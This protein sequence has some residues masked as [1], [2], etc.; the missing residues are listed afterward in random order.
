[1]NHQ[2]TNYSYISLAASAHG[3]MNRIPARTCVGNETQEPD[4]VGCT[5]LPAAAQANHMERQDSPRARGGDQYEELVSGEPDAAIPQSEAEADALLA[6]TGMGE[7]RSFGRT[8][9]IGDRYL[10]LVTEGTGEKGRIAR[11]TDRL[12]TLGA[13]LVTR[14][15]N[16][17]LAEGLTPVALTTGMTVESP[18]ETMARR[19]GSGLADAAERAGIL[20]LRGTM[21]IRPDMGSNLAVVGT[22]AG[23]AEP[24]AVFPGEAATGDRLVGFPSGGI[25]S[26][27]IEL[28]LETLTSAYELAEPLP[29]DRSR[30]IGDVLVEPSR[31]YTYLTDALRE[32]T[33]HAA[34]VIGDNGWRD[35]DGMGE[36]RYTISDTF[37]PQPLFET[38]QNTGDHDLETMYGS[39]NMGTGFVL[40]APE[41]AAKSIVSKTDGRI[42]G[43]VEQGTGISIRG[44]EL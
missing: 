37:D 16:E 40:A 11:E 35:L 3:R 10:G 6:V 15:V 33:V 27:G 20:L 21:E 7:H 8:I 34:V 38:I 5:H 32:E 13:D 19:I 42:I 44:I 31:L 23:V 17:L 41:A 24:S 39:F 14:T 9:D 12:A 25:H 43:A 1:M 2:F 28:A 36:Y 18:D 4:F 26:G 29:G 30:T 22:A